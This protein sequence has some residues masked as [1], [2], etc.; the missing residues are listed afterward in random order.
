MCLETEA[1]SASAGTWPTPEIGIGKF[2][3]GPEPGPK[4]FESVQPQI[5]KW[6]WTSQAMEMLR[7]T[8]QEDVWDQ[9][10]LCCLHREQSQESTL[11]LQVSLGTMFNLSEPQFPHLESTW[12]RP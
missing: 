10:V 4:S 9:G 1:I 12:A 3:L 5:Q 7:P 8:L 6:E 11:C 2:P